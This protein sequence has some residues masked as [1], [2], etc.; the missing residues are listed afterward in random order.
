VVVTDP[1]AVWL[2]EAAE[3]VPSDAALAEVI[4][5]PAKV[6]AMCQISR[7]AAEDSDPAAAEVIG[8]G[9]ARGLARKIDLAWS[10]S[11]ASPAPSGLELR[12]CV[13]R[14]W[15]RS[16][17]WASVRFAAPSRP[18]AAGGRRRSS[19]RREEDATVELRHLRSFMATADEG[20]VTQAAAPRGAASWPR[21][22]AVCR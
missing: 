5:T 16:P 6:G 22:P 1:S 11:L 2:A 12:F 7:E 20:S 3:L 17:T 10:G 9:L 18:T 14:P 13:R 8:Q 21:L 15:P 4:V 19:C